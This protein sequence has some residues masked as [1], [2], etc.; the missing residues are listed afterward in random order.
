[1][2]KSKPYTIKINEV[3]KK[4]ITKYVKNSCVNKVSGE[5][6]CSIR[7]NNTILSGDTSEYDSIIGIALIH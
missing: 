5:T 1:M 6:S 3:P 2:T 7:L 4:D